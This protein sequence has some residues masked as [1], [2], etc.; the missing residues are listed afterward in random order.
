MWPWQ[1]WAAS[2]GGSLPRGTTWRDLAVAVDATD[3]FFVLTAVLFV[4]RQQP[5]QVKDFL[6]EPERGGML[7]M[8]LPQGLIHR[9]WLMSAAGHVLRQPPGRRRMLRTLPNRTVKSLACSWLSAWPTGLL[10]W[11]SPEATTLHE[12]RLARFSRGSRRH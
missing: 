1:S 3:S 12:D 6:V 8:S 10:H 4:L 7:R 9:P 11:I 2:K 5:S